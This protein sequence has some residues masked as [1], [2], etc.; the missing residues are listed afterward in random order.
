M[1]SAHFEE[2]LRARI[3]E[4]EA[5]LSGAEHASGALELDPSRVGRLSRMDAIQSQAMIAAVG[6]RRERDLARAKAALGRIERGEYGSC[7]RCE[8][9]I[10]ER[11]LELDPSATLCV[12]CAKANERG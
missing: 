2:L 12:D 6:R 10:A 1:D 11:R 3:D 9:P 4:L 5:A 8:E 7:L